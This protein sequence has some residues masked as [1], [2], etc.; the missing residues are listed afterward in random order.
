MGTI[1]IRHPDL[2]ITSQEVCMSGIQPGDACVTEFGDRYDLLINLQQV[3]KRLKYLA[4]NEE[5]Q[6]RV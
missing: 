6:E 4:A 1:Y 2:A 3:S 5:V